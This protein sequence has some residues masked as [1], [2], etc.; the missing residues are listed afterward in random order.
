M[1]QICSKRALRCLGNA[2]WSYKRKAAGRCYLYVD[3]EAALIPFQP[4]STG[5]G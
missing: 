5:R 4:Y 1:Y 2:V 3:R